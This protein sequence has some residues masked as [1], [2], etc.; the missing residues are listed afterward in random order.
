M[1]KST[2][3]AGVT[4]GVV[5]CD[6]TNNTPT[7]IDTNQLIVDVVIQPSRTAEFITLRTTVQRTG[8]NLSVT[9]TTIIGG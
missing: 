2:N 3:P 9:E 5:I 7:I 1:I 8:E 4:A 6:A